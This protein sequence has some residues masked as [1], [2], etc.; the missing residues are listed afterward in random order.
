VGSNI[1][2]ASENAEKARKALLD[3]RIS[4]R[5]VGDFG[6]QPRRVIVVR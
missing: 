3:A 1:E 5:V 4:D 2:A 6:I